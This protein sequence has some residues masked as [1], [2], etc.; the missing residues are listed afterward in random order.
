MNIRLFYGSSTGNTER[1]AELIKDAWDDITV[2][3]IGDADPEDLA[4]ADGLI[5]GTS[6]WDDGEL[7]EDWVAWMENF[8]DIDLSGKKVALFGLGDGVGFA[9]NF[10]DAMGT[11][12]AKVVERGASIIGFWPTEGYEYSVSTALIDGKFCGLGIDED[13][14]ADQ[15]DERV[16]AW[17]EQIKG[18]FGA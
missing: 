10:L 6:T 18:E 7:Q 15:T 5:L 1:V 14:Q 11:L 17:V 8:D 9:D 4:E 16:E 2:A 12:Y 13:N 3:A